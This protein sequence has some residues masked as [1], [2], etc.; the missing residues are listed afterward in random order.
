MDQGSGVAMNCGRGH[1]CSSDPTLLW[2]WRRLAA[3]AVTPS[4]GISICLRCGPKEQKKVGGCC[5]RRQKSDQ[6]SSFGFVAFFFCLVGWFMFCLG[7][8]LAMWKFQGQGSNPG[9]LSD[10][11]RSFNLLRQENSCVPFL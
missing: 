5:N 10:S 9:C 2:L 3:A 8:I 7:R 6:H 4:L 1:R 11:A